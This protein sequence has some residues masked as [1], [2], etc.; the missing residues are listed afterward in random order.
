MTFIFYRITKTKCTNCIAL[1]AENQKLKADCERLLKQ[2]TEAQGS[3]HAPSKEQTI[4]IA[5]VEQ[6]QTAAPHV[7][8]KMEP[9]TEMD[10]E[11]RLQ[12]DF[13]EIKKDPLDMEQQKEEEEEPEEEGEAASIFDDIDGSVFDDEARLSDGSI[14]APVS[15]DLI[16]AS[17]PGKKFWKLEDNQSRWIRL[18]LIISLHH[19]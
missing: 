17:V 10:E 6:D 13:V 8:V 19:R 3:K 2:L 7:E 1:L 5:R 18:K 12:T 11:L 4:E 9:M 15:G 16:K 14:E